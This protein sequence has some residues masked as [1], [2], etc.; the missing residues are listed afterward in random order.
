MKHILNILTFLLSVT[1]VAE[2]IPVSNAL[3]IHNAMDGL[4]PGDTLL[5]T[6]GVWDDQRISLHAEGTD[7]NPIVLIAETPGQVLL[8]GFSTLN[9]SGSYIEIN[10]LNFNEGYSTGGNHVI[11]FRRNGVRA[12]H[13]RVTNTTILNY[14]PPSSGTDYKWIS[15][16]GQHNRVDHCYLAG[17]NHA[18][19]TMVI[20]LTEAQDR[21]NHHIIEYNYFGH[22]PDLGVN[23]G[24]TIRIGTSDY[25]MTNSRS[26]VRH[27][28]FEQCDGEIE[29]ISSKSCENIYFNNTFLNNEGMLTLRHGERCVVEGNFFLG[30]GNSE[31][32]GV[33]IIGAD[34]VVI[35]NYFENL[36]GNGYRSGI[37]FVK[38]VEDSPLNRYFQVEN[39]LVAY[40]TLVNCRQSFLMGYGSSDDQTLP[41]INCTIANNAVY[42]WNNPV[43]FTGD[44]EGLP[45]N[46]S[47]LQ[48]MVMG[49]QL[50]IPDT[51]A[52]IIWQDPLFDFTSEGLARP[53]AGSPLIGQ[54]AVLD[55]DVTTDMDGQARGVSR[56]IG[57]DQLSTD[58]I[59]YRPL[60]RDD[61]GPNW[62]NNVHQN[63][64]VEAGLNTL[65]DAV[66]NLIPGDTIFLSG[67]N[68]TL[69]HAIVVDRD[70]LILPDPAINTIPVI[71]PA[72]SYSRMF[73][74]LGGKTLRIRGVNLDGGGDNEARVQRLFH[75]RYDNPNLVY[76]LHV[77][78][79]KITGIGTTGDLANVLE[80]EVNTLADSIVFKSCDFSAANGELFILDKTGDE[81]GMFSAR[82]VLF[83]DCSFWDISRSILSI[84]GGDSNPFS[85]G[86]IVMVN[87]CT[88]YHCGYNNE[89]VINARNVD[90]ATIKNCIF[91]ESSQSDNL[92]ELYSWSQIL[93]TDVYNSGDISLHPNVT[94]GA[95]ILY[96]DPQF[97]NPAEGLLD[98]VPGSVLYDYPGTDGLAYGD[99]RR[100][101]PSVPQAIDQPLENDHELVSNFPNPFNGGTTLRFSLEHDSQ[102]DVQ[103]FDLTGRQVSHP[104]SHRFTAGA[105]QLSLNLDAFES[106]VYMCR[107]SMGIEQQMTKMTVIK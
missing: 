36:A 39:A 75:A 56:D 45:Q 70:I 44:T 1:L 73:D 105:H 30:E 41:P 100:H 18:A 40:N 5:M 23:G 33:R 20:W 63:I 106:G 96:V 67:D 4:N 55:Y 81:S 76:S 46:F 22:R 103:I 88:F 93:Y 34:H 87:H 48:N 16:Y 89:T 95:G 85:V 8:T 53:L 79:S 65:A 99:R 37:V 10:G 2:T 31:A 71:S 12:N 98:L 24:E 7:T 32:G 62:M 50:G 15:L 92:V 21:E 101:D 28:L 60:T 17:K 58:P 82:N 6:N 29:I 107:V 51:S 47:Y 42:T 97:A 68:F 77:E 64:Y 52:G 27:N 78:G 90:V 69:D 66:V 94:L 72:T 35:N 25:S 80:A 61:V 14:N 102:V 26:M 54:A 104:V 43:F 57:A 3:E 49:S 13:C 11:E 74:I 83:E 86:P 91:S 38:G 84:Y 59:I 9:F 19:T